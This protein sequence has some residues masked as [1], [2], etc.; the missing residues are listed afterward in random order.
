[1]KRL[2]V[3][4]KRH[5]RQMLTHHKIYLAGR[6]ALHNAKIFNETVRDIEDYIKQQ[7]ECNDVVDDDE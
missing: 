5:N 4:I 2:E 6:T 1:M 3:I 7:C